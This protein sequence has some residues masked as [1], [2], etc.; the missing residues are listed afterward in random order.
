[1]GKYNPDAPGH[2]SFAESC[3]PASNF[4]NREISIFGILFGILFTKN[5]LQN[6][7]QGISTER[8]EICSG[9]DA[10][11]HLGVSVSNLCGQARPVPGLGFCEEVGAG[12]QAF[13]HPL[14]RKNAAPCGA[15]PAFLIALRGEDEI[16]TRGTE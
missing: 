13:R 16:R 11:A 2:P 4:F 5:A 9:A 12:K 15:A 8:G 6:I 3:Q 14:P 7:L 10:F 1:M